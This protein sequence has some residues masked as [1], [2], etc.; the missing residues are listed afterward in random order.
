VLGD[1]A[2]SKS[3]VRALRGAS[4]VIHAAALK[5]VPEA[6][7]N[8]LECIR[9][10]VNG[11]L[12]LID[13]AVDCGVERVLGISTDKASSPVNLYGATKMIAERLLI[14]A[15]DSSRSHP[16][17]FSIVR[18]GNVLGSSGSFVRA[19][20]AL[21]SDADI[22]V[23]DPEMT[24]FWISPDQAVD[25]VLLALHSMRGGEIFVPRMP[26]MKV[27]D[28]AAAIAPGRRHRVVGRRPGEKVHEE[29]IGS[30][31]SHLVRDCG[32]YFVVCRDSTVG[33]G[34][35]GGAPV[36]N[37]FRYSSDQNNDWL[38]ASRLMDLVNSVG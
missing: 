4:I 16:T 21:P 20:R 15:N 33:G 25:F 2:D 23:T 35:A 6:E 13:A 29:L 34:G 26:S 10:N 18:Y 14:G 30:H 36:D 1:V 5:H 27:V 9:T 38:D 17:H 19:L 31:E 7:D 3:L 11:C 28:V 12:N 8:P 37:G 22:P 24:R 32:Q